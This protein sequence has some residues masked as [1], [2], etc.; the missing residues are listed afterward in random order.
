MSN[1]DTQNSTAPPRTSGVAMSAKPRIAIH[2]ATGAII[3][4]AP[5]QKCANTVSRFVNEYAQMKMRTG[6]ARIGGQGFDGSAK[7]KTAVDATNAVALIRV[8]VQT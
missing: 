4:D 3:N 8:S 7:R 2:A 5:S 1:P 6:T